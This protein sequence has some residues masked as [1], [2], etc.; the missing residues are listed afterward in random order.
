M[1]RPRVCSW[2]LCGQ[3]VQ[4][5]KACFLQVTLFHPLASFGFISSSVSMM[6]SIYLEMICVVHSVALIG[7]EN[8]EPQR[9]TWIPWT[10]SVKKESCEMR[11]NLIKCRHTSWTRGNLL[12]HRITLEKAVLSGSGGRIWEK[13]CL[14]L[15]RVYKTCQSCTETV[16][17]SVMFL[18]LL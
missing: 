7:E 10:Y 18:E 11:Q 14:C 8:W 9:H 15:P 17:C 5:K 16:E 13:W 2:L 1:S 12:C 3:E 4:T 6:L